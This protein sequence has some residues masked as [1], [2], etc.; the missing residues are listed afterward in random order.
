MDKTI[1]NPPDLTYIA[2]KNQRS[3]FIF[4]STCDFSGK[5]TIRF[6]C[7]N[8]SAIEKPAPQP[9]IRRNHDRS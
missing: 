1:P 9:L 2:Q 5:I 6:S 8:R 7:T 4:K 3:I